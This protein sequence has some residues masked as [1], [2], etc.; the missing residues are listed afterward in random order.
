MASAPPPPLTLASPS[1]PALPD[2]GPLSSWSCASSK[3][4]ITVECCTIQQGVYD[5]VGGRCHN[6]T[7]K[8]FQTCSYVVGTHGGGY[9]IPKSTCSSAAGRQGDYAGAVLLALVAWA[10]LS[11]LAAV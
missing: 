11:V 5:P 6:V 7:T 10:G 4:A 9:D 2:P 1:S 8:D 3:P